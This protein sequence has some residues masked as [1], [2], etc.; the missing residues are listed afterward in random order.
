MGIW[1][2]NE[3]VGPPLAKMMRS[4]QEREDSNSSLIGSKSFK[5]MFGVV[6]PEELRIKAENTSAI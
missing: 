1:A 2:E 5:A 6:V 3:T 4:L